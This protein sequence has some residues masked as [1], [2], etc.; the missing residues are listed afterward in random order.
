MF[1]WHEILLDWLEKGQYF[2]SRDKICGDM[3]SETKQKW[4][5]CIQSLPYIITDFYL[6]LIV[7]KL[8]DRLSPEV[9]SYPEN[10]LVIVSMPGREMEACY[11]LSLHVAR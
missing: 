5:A 7:F 10:L 1:V 6:L 9:I 2:V 8:R 4:Q 11:K 3:L